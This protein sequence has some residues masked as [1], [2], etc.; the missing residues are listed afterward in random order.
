MF[1]TID[2]EI[3]K[4]TNRLAFMVRLERTAIPGLFLKVE[5]DGRK[6]V[7]HQQHIEQEP[8]QPSVPVG[9][10]M[11]I[12]ESAMGPCGGL[13]DRILAVSVLAAELLPLLK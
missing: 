6:R 4:G 3:H 8:S 11:D 13:Q 5:D 1:Q 7:A 12:L 2:E 9:E 10:G